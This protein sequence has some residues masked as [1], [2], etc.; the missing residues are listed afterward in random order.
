VR[1]KIYLMIGTAVLFFASVVYAKFDPS[2]IWTTLETPHFL[3]HFHQGGEDLAKRAAVIA[4]D[5]HQ[6]MSPRMKWTPSQKTHLVLAD[7]ADEANGQTS[8]IPY[9]Q[10]ILYV[11][12][13]S[14]Q[15]GF[16][17][18]AYD[19]WLRVLITHEYTHALHMDMVNGIPKGIQT[20]FGRIYFP[21]MFEPVWMI[22]GLATYEETELT[23]GGRGRS[24][25]AEMVLRMAA[26]EGP[27]PELPQASVYPDFWP[28]GQVPYLFG[29]S[30]T[31]YIAEKYGRDTLADISVA[32]SGRGFPF[33]VASTGEK[34]LHRSY[35]DLW[36]E[37]KGVLKDRFRQ[38]EQTIRAQGI[39]SSNVLTRRGNLNIS[40]AFAP[41]GKRIAYSVVNSD[42]F[43]GIFIMNVDGS[44]DRKIVE[45][46]FSTSASG[47][48]LAWSPDGTRLYYTKR[49]VQGNTNL[50][51]DLY[52]F[53][54]TTGKELRLT[55]GLRARD[56]HPS[57][58]GKKLVFVANRMAHNRLGVLNIS[59]DRQQPVA[60]SD[61]VWLGP[62]SPDQYSTPQWSH[63][64]TKIAVCVHQANG[65][66]DIRLLDA[67]GNKLADISQ[68]R[69]LDGAPAWSSDDHYLY[70]SSDRSGIFNLYAYE[71][72]TKTIFQI[73]NVLG[74]AFTPSPSPDNT[75]LAFSSYSAAGYDIHMLMLDKASWKSAE[76]YHDPYPVVQHEDRPVETKA[77]PYSPLGT[78][79]PRFWLPWLGYSQASGTLY[80][81]FTFG[82]DVVQHHQYYFTAL[83]GPQHDRIWYD[84]DYYYDGLYPT[85]RAHLTDGDNIFIGMLNR[86]R[87]YVERDRMIDLSL[88]FPFVKT[89]KQHSLIAGYRWK[90]LSPLTTLLPYDVRPATGVMSSIKAGYKFNNARDYGHSI[91][92]EQ[93]RTFELGYE[94][95]DK[96]IGSDIDLRKYT[97]DW[98]EFI[99]L[100]WQHHVL[101]AR[102]FAGSSSGDIIP[103]RAYQ[104]G[105]DNRG[106][107]TLSPDDQVVDLRG[108]PVNALR[109]QK[110]A[111]ATLEY[112]FPIID[113]DKGWN[114]KPIYFRRM[115][116]A[117]FYEAGNAWDHA[118]HGD[119]LKRSAG[120]ELRFDLF[121]AYYL[122]V[123]MRIVFANGLDEQGQK[124][125]Y[126]GF[127][128]PIE[129]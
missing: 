30:F 125:L 69:A 67:L 23:S 96:N 49:D 108:Y 54:L 31:R 89:A 3:I 107:I 94:R 117:V 127:W 6:R 19:D 86:N 35:A 2:F 101:L 60:Q 77:S 56:P 71:M 103:Q 63:D 114:T 66:Q 88:V 112:R 18:T 92:P 45:N 100:P 7:V 4:E 81:L 106:D 73:T 13:P 33:L 27:F 21:N 98:H 62:E 87:E 91:S 26:L 78:I 68:D 46:A 55:E 53:D 128:A 34:V 12:Q 40:P 48:S 121:L 119:E 42:E 74:G 41:D 90:N 25:G 105:G 64:G 82:Q 116:G 32:Y 15:P 47:S 43:P 38:Q 120:A 123:T 97:V 52:A 1:N 84:L 61:I 79:Y 111:L 80:G 5:V 36:E 122:P 22:E 93:G 24:P 8:P 37:W 99:N 95:L 58:D 57:L 102:M 115:H 28:S 70:F 44:N 51:N 118:F 11:T 72:E 29:E 110:A 83:Y 104:L 14:G 129:L 126:L 75:R 17:A 65:F 39:T 10:I 16:G 124:V 20:V 113:L 59:L 9:D 109:G 85:V 76:P 50:F